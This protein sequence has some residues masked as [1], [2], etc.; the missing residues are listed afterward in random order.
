MKSLILL[1]ATSTLVMAAPPKAPLTKYTPL[2]T[3]SPFTSKPPIDEGPA[4]GPNPLED[5]AL[6]GISPITGGYRVTLLNR[7]N[8][9]ERVTIDTD[10]KDQAHGF[11]V[12]SVDRKPGDPLATVVH[13]TK[14]ANKGSVEFD[15]ALLTLKAPPPPQQAQQARP[16]A[17]PVLGQPQIGVPGTPI[18]GVRN[19]VVQPP[20]PIP[21]PA[22]TGA[23][24]A[25]PAAQPQSSGRGRDYRRPD[26][27]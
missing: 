12:D 20:V 15:S 3:N 23:P 2:W 17:P 24:V 16:G 11:V 22:A 25:P 13:L 5:Y 18:P 27:R 4:A 14:G 1:F 9:E 8:P 26:R 6:G 10:R 7:K 19:R 21:T